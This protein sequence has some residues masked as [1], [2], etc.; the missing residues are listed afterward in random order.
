MFRNPFAADWKYKRLTL[1]DDGFDND[2]ADIGSGWITARV[3]FSPRWKEKL[4]R[5]SCSAIAGSFTS[6]S[7]PVATVYGSPTTASPVG[8]STSSSFPVATVYGSPTTASPVGSSTSSSF[9]VATVYGSP[10]T[11]PPFG[12]ST[13]SSVPVATVYGSPTTASPVGSSTSSSVPVATVYGSPTTAPPVG[14]STSSSF[15]VATVY[16][17]PT[18][19]TNPYVSI[20]CKSCN[21][22][23]ADI[24]FYIVPGVT[25]VVPPT[26]STVAP[27]LSYSTTASP[28]GSSTSSSFPVATVYGS[29]TTASPVGSST[30]SSVPVATVYGSPTTTNE[31]DWSSTENTSS[32]IFKNETC[33]PSCCPINCESST[34]S[35]VD[36]I[37]Y[38]VSSA[39]IVAVILLCCILTTYY[40]K[41]CTGSYDIQVNKNF[42][43]KIYFSN[44]KTHKS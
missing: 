23:Q 41:K 11:A 29:P 24:I 4:C 26:T 5:P 15:P 7:V 42:I 2:P 1:N 33:I 3:A 30:S 9:P 39:A 18:T 20:N 43:C 22:S 21:Y 32:N 6:S 25:I 8:S 27:D 35:E 34:Y 10:T 19:T 16:G 31:P 14:S 12:S 13:S 17:S 44:I 28:V 38:T 37:I 36:V 40:K